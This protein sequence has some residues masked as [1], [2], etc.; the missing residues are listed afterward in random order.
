MSVEAVSIQAG[1]KTVELMA[2]YGVA[3]PMLVIMTVLFILVLGML[4][5]LWVYMVT[6]N[7]ALHKEINTLKKEAATD[8]EH[9]SKEIEAIKDTHKDEVIRI[10][11]D[12]NEARKEWLDST[13]DMFNK[14]IQLIESRFPKTK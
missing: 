12:Q 4:I 9:C 1:V 6:Q 8:R 11:F 14:A 5:R 13:Q 10:V 3:I 7:I 2:E